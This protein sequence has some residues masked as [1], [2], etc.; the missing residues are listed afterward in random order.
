MSTSSSSNGGG[1]SSNSMLCTLEKEEAL[2]ILAAKP[3]GYRHYLQDLD[4][5]GMILKW[6]ALQWILKNLNVDCIHLAVLYPCEHTAP[7]SCL[8]IHPE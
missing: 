3:E 8:Y 4:L 2:V 7:W 5:Y 1:D 6:T